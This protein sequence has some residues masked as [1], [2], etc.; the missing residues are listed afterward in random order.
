MLRAM[1]GLDGLAASA[2]GFDWQFAVFG[3]AP[4][5]AVVWLAPNTQ[6]ITGY[7][8]EATEGKAASPERPAAIWSASPIWATALGCVFAAGLLSLSKVSEFLYFQF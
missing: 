5:L 3:L 2:A 8:P 4:L 7:R 6:E 1:L